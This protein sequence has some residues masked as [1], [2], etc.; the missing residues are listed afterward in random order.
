METG[1]R[2]GLATSLRQDSEYIVVRS[3]D[4]RQS[5]SGLLGTG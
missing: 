3:D 5:E 2:L 1:H 4:E